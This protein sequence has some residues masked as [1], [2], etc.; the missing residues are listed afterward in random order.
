MDDI[1]ELNNVSY[2]YPNSDSPVLKNLSFSIKKGTFVAIMGHSGAGK[3]TLN[4]C[5][6]GLIPQLLEGSLTGDIRINAQ[7][8]TQ[9]SVPTMAKHVGL[10][11]DDP[12]SQIIGRTVEEDISFGPINF[13][14][15]IDEIRRRVSNTLKMVQ[16]EGFEQRDTSQLSG[17][18]KQRLA[19]AGILAM[20]PKILVLDEP[21][22][23]LDPIGRKEIYAT[24]NAYRKTQQLTIMITEHNCEDIIH[25][26][27]EV[28]VLQKGE[29]VWEGSPEVLFRNVPLLNKFWLRPLPVSLLGWEFYQKGWI[30]FDEIP[31]DVS[32][33]ENL[34]KRQLPQLNSLKSIS[35]PERLISGNN[36]P[37][38][39]ILEVTDLKHEY[40]SGHIAIQSVNLSIKEGEFVALIGQN[41]SG[42]TTLAKHFNGLLE[43]TAGT[44][45]V[46]GKDTKQFSTSLLAREIGY[47]FQNPDHQLFSSTVEQE[48]AYGL[49]NMDIEPRE[50]QERINQ[51]L[52]FTGLEPLR[53]EHP[54]SLGKGERQLVAVASVLVLQPKILVIDEPTTGLDWRGIQ[55]LLTLIKNLHDN[56]T[57]IVMISHDMEIV[58]KYAQRVILMANGGILLDGDIKEVFRNTSLLEKAGIVPPQC[59]RLSLSLKPLGLEEVFLHEDDFLQVLVPKLEESICS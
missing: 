38:R 11:L 21:G 23:E 29:L 4:L 33:A 17:G 37:V 40:A 47:V 44:V 35:R 18:E 26:V 20:L 48:L 16:L 42:K 24:I 45:V 34:I 31:L 59:V 12:E 58:A 6:N 49:K 50:I 56:G 9:C 41:G 27:D 8:L 2:S 3:T 28:K 13:C 39:T 46:D 15:S 30:T 1:I 43:P 52:K 36:T 5:L 7:D 54:L 51:V 10:V 55:S 32:Q 25:R 22:S 57:T 19:I 53:N 14:L